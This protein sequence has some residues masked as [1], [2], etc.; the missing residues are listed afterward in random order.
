MFYAKYTFWICLLGVAYTY[1]LY[2]IILFLAYSGAQLWRDI[3]YLGKRRSTRAVD[4]ADAELPHVSLVGAA[5]NE[6]RVLS[7]RIANLNEIDYP[8]DKLEVIFISDGSTDGTNL[9]LG[10]LHRPNL[11]KII[12]P[13]RGGKANA[14]N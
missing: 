6:A 3:S 14:L 4:L 10:R 1:L 5:Y 11:Q 2:P 12:L 8:A 7:E 13:E 9:I